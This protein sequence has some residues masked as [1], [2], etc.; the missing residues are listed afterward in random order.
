MN[1]LLRRLAAPVAVLACLGLAACTDNNLRARDRGSVGGEGDDDDA[2]DDDDADEGI[3]PCDGIDN[4]GDGEVDEGHPD[5]DGDG[6]ADCV[7]GGC[8][9]DFPTIGEVP[10]NE[11]CGEEGGIVMPQDPWNIRIQW[12]WSGTTGNASLDDVISTPVVGNLTDDDFDGDVDVDDVPDIVALA[13]PDLFSEGSVVAMDG[14]TGATLWSNPGWD[15]L[16]GVAMA[17]V[18]GDGYTDIVGAGTGGQIRAIDRNGNPMWSTPV[19]LTTYAPQATVADL[20]GNG[21]VE[22]IVD[23]FIVAG[24]NGQLISTLNLGDYIPY[25]VPAVGDIDLDGRQEIILGNRAFDMSGAT[26]W[27]AGFAG[28]YGHWAAIVN[29]DSDPEGEVAMVGQGLFGVYDHDGTEL[30]RR[31]V[32]TGQ[33]GAPCVADFDGDGEAE[34]GWASTGVFSMIE[35]DGSTLW[36]RTV[37][38]NSG[39]AACS[40]YDFN[41]DGQYE[42]LYADETT[43]WIFDGPTGNTLHSTG[44]HASGTLWEYPVVADIDGDDSAEIVFGSNDGWITGFSGVTALTH[45]TDEWMKS[46]TTWGVHDFAVTNLNPDGTVPQ[47]P[48]PSWQAHNVYRARPVVDGYIPGIDLTVEVT[49]VCFSGCEATNLVSIVAQVSNYGNA[50]SLESVPVSLYATNGVDDVLVAT[51]YIPEPV[52]TGGQTAGILFEVPAVTL[53]DAWIKVVVDDPAAGELH[54]ECDETNNVA[55]F[56]DTPCP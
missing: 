41:G 20:D 36:S 40:G 34:I 42:V 49:D 31:S 52:P 29:A 23:M 39:L 10:V 53:R 32:G 25:R 4:D 50:D 15:P 14:G 26:E 48:T 38:D 1:L 24:S 12:Q 21:T 19:G 43:L 5:T 11:E 56:N 17:D 37:Q 7:D 35:L 16:G 9:V 3:D 33:P 22:V 51:R 54:I 27:T 44:G 30:V 6:I 55:E 13:S 46:G 18:D 28:S 45:D 2:V 8:T 47:N